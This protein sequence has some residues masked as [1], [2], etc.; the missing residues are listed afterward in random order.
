MDTGT[1]TEI[2]GGGSWTVRSLRGNSEARTYVCPGC[3]QQLASGQP[4][5]VVWP[6]DGLGGLSDRRHWHTPC[7]QARDRRPPRGS[8]K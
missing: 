2:Y 6:T 1:R 5:V 7:W 8:W 4:H 3:Q